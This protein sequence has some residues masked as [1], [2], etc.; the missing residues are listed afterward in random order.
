MATF[1]IIIPFYQKQPGILHRALTAVFGQGFQD[2]D[3]IIVDDESPSAVDRDLD[4]LSAGERS[5][6][7][8]IRQPNAGP[9][10]ARNTGLENVPA[11]TRFVAFLDSDDVWMPGHLENAHASLTRFDGD[12]YFASIRGGEEFYYHFNMLELAKSERVVEL[13]LTPL[14]MEVPDIASVMLKNWSFLHL[15]CM[16]LARPLFEKVRFEAELRLAAE[17]V[18]FFSDCMLAAKRVL[19]CNEDGA[20][21]GRGVNIFHGIDNDSPQFVRQQFNTWIALD[22]LEQRFSRRPGDVASIRSYKDNA[23]RQ[24]LWSQMRQIR[25]RKVPQIALLARWVLRDPSILQSAVKLA[26][27]KLSS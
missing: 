4:L 13:S 2:F 18:L 5:R 6:I 12:C 1:T 14:V 8:V 3:V 26:V 27:G 15:S 23:R 10:G 11:M 21:R 20:L 25:R 9:G 22:T 16:A 19:L 24:A 17:D 7:T